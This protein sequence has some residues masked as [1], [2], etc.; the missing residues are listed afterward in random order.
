L[1]AEL[2]M[3]G[4]LGVVSSENGTV[5]VKDISSKKERTV[6]QSSVEWVK[7]GHIT[8][9]RHTSL[10]ALYKL[11]SNAAK[12]KTIPQP[13]AESEGVKGEKKM[14]HEKVNPLL[15]H[16]TKEK[17]ETGEEAEEASEDKD[18]K[19]ESEGEDDLWDEDGLKLSLEEPLY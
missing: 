19:E 9:W 11:I 15:H 8:S 1:A 3:E 12:R 17:K 2:A 4:P 7:A 6:D 16:V 18:D 5:M 10:Q 13:K 14:V